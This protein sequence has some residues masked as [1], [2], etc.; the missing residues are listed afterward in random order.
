MI[1]HMKPIR[2]DKRNISLRKNQW[3]L[4]INKISTQS[5]V[6]RNARI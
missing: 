5:E 2:N 3:R 6:N 4:W 1:L